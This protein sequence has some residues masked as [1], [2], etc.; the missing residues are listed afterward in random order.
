[1]KCFAC[2]G[3][4]GSSPLP[5]FSPSVRQKPRNKVAN[6]LRVWSRSLRK[7]IRRRIS[8]SRMHPSSN[9]IRL[10]RLAKRWNIRE[11]LQTPNNWSVNIS[12]W[13]RSTT[14]CTCSIPTWRPRSCWWL[15]TRPSGSRQTGTFHSTRLHLNSFRRIR[16]QSGLQKCCLTVWVFLTLNIVSPTGHRLA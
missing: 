8:L 11:R 7:V 2:H 9:C 14:S 3:G 13:S 5:C 1:M 6:L 10:R 15:P 12:L 16:S 4:G